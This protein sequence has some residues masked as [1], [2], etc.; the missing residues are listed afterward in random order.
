MQVAPHHQVV[1][2][3]LL[4][5]QLGGAFDLG[6]AVA[7]QVGQPGIGS[8]LGAHL[9]QVDVLRAAGRARREGQ[10]LVLRQRVDRRRLAGIAAADEGD[11]RPFGH[12][13]LVELAGGDQKAGGVQPGQGRLGGGRIS[14]AGV[15]KGRCHGPL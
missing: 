7:R 1:G 6:I 5:A 15:A 12:G 4:P 11:L 8:V 10:P 14:A 13:Q 3:H 2:H 9:E